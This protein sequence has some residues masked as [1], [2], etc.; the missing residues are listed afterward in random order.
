MQLGELP[1]HDQYLTSPWAHIEAAMAFQ[2]GLPILILRETGVL[3]DGILERGVTGLYLPEFDLDN[4]IDAYLDSAEFRQ[5]FEQWAH[6]VQSVVAT[7]GQ[8]PVL[9]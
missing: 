3:D 5:L 7:K 2:S 1:I 8:P 4:P 6:Q 9:Y